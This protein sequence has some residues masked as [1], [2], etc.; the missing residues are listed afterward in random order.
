M[1]NYEPILS[2]NAQAAETYDAVSIRGDEAETVE[3]L[4]RLANGRPALELAIGTGRI[5]IQHPLLLSKREDRT[6]D[7]LRGDD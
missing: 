5:A 4:A 2:F 6:F 1:D 7:S 3:F